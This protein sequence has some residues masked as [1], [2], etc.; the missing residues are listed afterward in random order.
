MILSSTLL[1]ICE[2]ILRMLD[3]STVTDTPN[4]FIDAAVWYNYNYSGSRDYNYPLFGIVK[5]VA[6]LV[7]I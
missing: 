5:F 7:C 2:W 4:R 1:R 3:G 6:G